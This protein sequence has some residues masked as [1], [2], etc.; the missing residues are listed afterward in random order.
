M[1]HFSLN[2]VAPVATTFKLD[3][4]LTNDKEVYATH[5]AIDRDKRVV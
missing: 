2:A 4:D 5:P 3:K 1:S